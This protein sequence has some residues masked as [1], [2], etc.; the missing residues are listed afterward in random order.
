MHTLTAAAVQ[1][2]Q[3]ADMGCLIPERCHDYALVTLY[4]Q[5]SGYTTAQGLHVT[6]MTMGSC[7]NSAVLYT[8]A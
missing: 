2:R 1:D 6:Y 8:H 7:S 4:R 5:S 3:L